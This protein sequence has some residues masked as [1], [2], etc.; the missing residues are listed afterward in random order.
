MRER[1]AEE[2]LQIAEEREEEESKEEVEQRE[3]EEESA[4]EA[5]EQV[6][7]TKV[8]LAANQSCM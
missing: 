5:N 1:Y 4:D 3:R 8:N 2:G 6:G 7:K